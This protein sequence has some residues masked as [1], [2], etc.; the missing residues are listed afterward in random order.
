MS[1]YFSYKTTRS[2]YSPAN[3]WPGFNTTPRPL[4]LR[5]RR[6]SGFRFCFRYTI[7]PME[8]RCSIASFPY[9]TLPPVAITLCVVRIW[10]FTRFSTSIKPSVPFSSMISRSSLPSAFWIS[11]SA[12]INS[13]PRTFAR[14]TPMVLFPTPGM[15]IKTI[16]SFFIS[17]LNLSL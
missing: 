12:S 1:A 3:V 15:P 6:S 2:L 14:T 10:L 5:S 11:R 16:F 4:M 17:Q 7:V 8:P 9:T 13:Y